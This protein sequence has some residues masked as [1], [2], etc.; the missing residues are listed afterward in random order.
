MSERKWFGSPRGPPRRSRPQS[1]PVGEPGLQGAGH[2]SPRTEPAAGASPGARGAQTSEEGAVGLGP[3]GAGSRTGPV[4]RESSGRAFSCYPGPHPPQG[5]SSP[6]TKRQ[7]R[8]TAPGRWPGPGAPAGAGRLARSSC[9]R[10]YLGRDVVR[11]SV[12]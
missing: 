8:V 12:P 10:L 1:A 5:G 7:A 3:G 6:G 4:P 11:I 2:R 9:A